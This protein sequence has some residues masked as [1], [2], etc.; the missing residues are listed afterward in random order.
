M[1]P[2]DG[3]RGMIEV[4][5][6]VN[7]PDYHTFQQNTDCKAKVRQI[8]EQ[9]NEDD[10]VSE[11]DKYSKRN[12]RDY[13]QQIIDEFNNDNHK[14]AKKAVEKGHIRKFKLDTPWHA[15]PVMREDGLSTFP[16]HHKE[17]YMYHVTYN[18]IFFKRGK[19]PDNAA[20]NASSPLNRGDA[21]KATPSICWP[22]P[23]T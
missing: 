3:T 23:Q 13:A 8:L 14:P 2:D 9:K 1:A 12:G 10:L 20:K 22:T 16:F 5:E 15:F 7:W 11:L 19:K 4:L 21:G 6:S 17:A 18:S